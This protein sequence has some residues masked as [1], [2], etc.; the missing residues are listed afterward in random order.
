MRFRQNKPKPNDFA[1][2][3]SRNQGNISP[4]ARVNKGAGPVASSD[5]KGRRAVVRGDLQKIAT[6]RLQRFVRCK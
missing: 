6:E 2:K 5:A 3:K 1:G 4:F